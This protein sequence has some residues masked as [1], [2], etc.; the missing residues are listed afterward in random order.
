MLEVL[1]QALRWQKQGK[2]VAL[3][4]VTA[5]RGSGPREPGAMLAV[6]ELGEVA[7]SVSGGCVEPAVVTEALARMKADSVVLER[8][9]LSGIELP[10]E[11]AMLEFGFS[12]DEAFAVGLTCGGTFEI[13]ILPS[14]WEFLEELVEAIREQI[15]LALC[16]VYNAKSNENSFTLENSV[17]ELPEVGAAMVVLEDG[18]RLGS[19]GNS[20]LDRVVARDALG[21][22]NSARGSRRNYGRRGQARDDEV[23]VLMA[24]AAK[25]AKMIIFGAVDFT[26][27]LV[28][29]ARFV[30]FSPVVVDARPIFATQARFPEAAEVVV[31]WPDRYLND[32]NDSIGPRDAICVLTHDPKFDVPAI[33]AALNTRAGYIGVMGSR[34]TQ[35][36]RRERLLALGISEAEMAKRVC[37]PIGLDL[38]ARTPEE[39]AVSIVGEIIAR[40]EGRTAAPLAERT[41]SIHSDGA[42]VW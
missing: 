27:A 28:R 8:F 26:L 20:D 30:G 11:P 33:Q 35:K 31:S 17:V 37:A 15:G 42:M 4:I 21:V 19:L 1:E 25:P 10:E 38:G 2:R 13:L 9:G 16:L 41:G 7:G 14:V 36:D 32:H 34:R 3:A 12:D 23:S 6:S 40:R 18:R 22:L 24:I 39:T 29:L 5:V